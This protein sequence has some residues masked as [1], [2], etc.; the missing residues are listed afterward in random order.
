VPCIC[1][2]FFLVGIRRLYRERRLRPTQGSGLQASKNL[3]FAAY[4]IWATGVGT[5]GSTPRHPTDL[6]CTAPITARNSTTYI[7][8]R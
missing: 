1:V 8:W 5:S 4:Y 7:I 3:Q 6:P 2:E